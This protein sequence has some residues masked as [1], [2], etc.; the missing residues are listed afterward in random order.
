MID[1]KLELL[2][3]IKRTEAPAALYDKVCA[4]LETNRIKYISP[5][6]VGLA[7][8]LLVGIFAVELFVLTKKTAGNSNP[9][10]FDYVVSHNQNLLYH[11]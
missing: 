6:R 1:N 4:R 5:L 7:A 8:S 2:S 3:K 10:A 11:D 9:K